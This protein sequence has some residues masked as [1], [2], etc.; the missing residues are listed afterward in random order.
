MPIYEYMCTSCGNEFEAM[1]KFSDAPL[2]E[3]ECGESGT[4]ERKLSLA[5]F[6]LKGGGWYKDRYAAG[7]NGKNGNGKSDGGDA[8]AAAKGES[9]DGG[10]AAGSEAV[11]AASHA[12]GGACSCA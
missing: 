3:C 5:A 11:K 1:Q 6:Q 2:T 7:G 4:V 8:G 10:S 12:C 9:K